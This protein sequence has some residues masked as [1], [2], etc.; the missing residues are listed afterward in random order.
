MTAMINLFVRGVGVP[1]GFR[2][3]KAR[4]AMRH[5]GNED[6]ETYTIFM[7]YAW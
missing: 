1:H 7:K 5:E 4:G 3:V 6:V 2:M